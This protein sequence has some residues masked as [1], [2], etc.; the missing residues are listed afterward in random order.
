[1]VQGKVDLEPKRTQG[2]NIRNQAW[3]LLSS[4]FLIENSDTVE[5]L[6]F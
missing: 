4:K 5:V 1:M 3:D 6:N 2:L